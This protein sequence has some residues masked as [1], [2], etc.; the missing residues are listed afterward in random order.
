YDH[1]THATDADIHALYAFLMSQRPVRNSVPAN[2]LRFP[3]NIRVLAAGWKVLFLRQDRFETDGSQS[4]EWNRGRY[5]VEGLGHCSACH[6]PRNVFGAEKKSSAYAGAVA[7]GWFA[8]ALN[9]SILTAHKW[10]AE[11]L[12]EFLSTGWHKMH[13]VAAG[14]MADVAKNLSQAPREDV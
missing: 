1:F 5:L 12:A 3:F 2:D 7:E 10:S 11:Q 4:A 8:P 13:G 9:S 6:T 14:P